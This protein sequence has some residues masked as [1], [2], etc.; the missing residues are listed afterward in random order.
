MAAED[1]QGAIALPLRHKGERPKVRHA[2]ADGRF[3]EQLLSF[4]PG[5]MS[6]GDGSGRGINLAHPAMNEAALPRGS[7]M[8][9][10]SQGRGN[11]AASLV[12]HHD[13]L[14]NAKL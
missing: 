4:V 14:G 2:L 11:P 10:A 12:T 7:V 9:A 8:K 3:L 13:D 6:L 5:T 1:D